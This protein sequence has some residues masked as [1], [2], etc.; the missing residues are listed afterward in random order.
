MNSANDDLPIFTLKLSTMKVGVLLTAPESITMAA[1]LDDISITTPSNDRVNEDYNCIFGLASSV[2]SSL[3]EIKYFKNSA[4]EAK[5]L[6]C[7]ADVENVE[8]F[9]HVSISK[10][11]F[12]HI[13][14]QILILT[15]YIQNGILG[16]VGGAKEGSGD[17]IISEESGASFFK[18]EGSEFE[19]VVPLEGKSINSAT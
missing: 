4:N 18:I 17:G 7:F 13:Q 3:L 14:A 11:R 10:I 5:K 6:D 16:V 8:T 1:S 12:V 19:I 9:C 2:S 15:D